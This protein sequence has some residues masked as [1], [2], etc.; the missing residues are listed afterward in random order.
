VSESRPAKTK[1]EA[2]TVGSVAVNL[3]DIAL[4]D[5][6]DATSIVKSTVIE[7]VEASATL[8]RR[9]TSVTPVIV[10]APGETLLRAAIPDANASCS[11]SPN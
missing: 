7:L 5:A 6:I 1:I 4:T 3:A 10:I 11:A 8:R 9:A 2:I